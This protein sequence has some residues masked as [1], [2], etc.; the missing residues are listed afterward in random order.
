MNLVALEENELGV[1][2]ADAYVACP[3]SAMRTD[4]IDRLDSHTASSNSGERDM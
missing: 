1:G 4:V 3:F 2:Q